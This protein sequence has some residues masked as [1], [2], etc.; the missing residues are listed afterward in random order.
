M[1]NHR[2]S[3]LSIISEI[4]SKILLSSII[5]NVTNLKSAGGN[6]VGLCPFHEEKSP[7]F[8]VR[9]KEAR[10]KC[11]GCGATGDHFDFLMKLRGL[12]FIEALEELKNLAGIT[13]YNQS[14]QKPLQ[15][16][17][18]ARYYYVLKLA[19]KFFSHCLQKHPKSLDYL[20]K[21]RGLSLTMIKEA[22]LGYCPKSSEL[23]LNYLQKNGVS[24]AEAFLC[25]L[26]KKDHM[27]P[28]FFDRITFPINDFNGHCIAFGARTLSLDSSVPKYINSPSNEFYEK[29]AAF[30][31][32]Y[33]S[34][35]AIDS[36]ASPYLVEGYFDAMAFWA[37]GFAAMALC[38]TSFSI[39]HALK[40]K[41]LTHHINICFDLDKAGINGLKSCLSILFSQ[42]LKADL[43]IIDQKDPGV[44]LEQKKIE[45][46]REK[47]I[48]K[49]DAFCFLLDLASIKASDNIDA[50]LKE[51]DELLPI[52]NS[53]K[54]DL[55]KRQYVSYF[56]NKI[57]EEPNIIWQ[58]LL[59]KQNKNKN[60][61]VTKN[62][63]FKNIP[64]P[65]TEKIILEILWIYPALI[66]HI[67][68]SLIDSL[69]DN[70]KSLFIEI[71]NSMNVETAVKNT[72]F[73]E[74]LLLLFKQKNQLNLSEPEALALIKSFNEQSIKQKTQESITKNLHNLK[75]A[76][77]NK[78]VEVMINSLKK[79]SELLALKRNKP[80]ADKEI[81]IEE[82]PKKAL[83]INTLAPKESIFSDEE[84]W[85]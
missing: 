63:G 41:K 8:N 72:G 83:K 32:A 17:K 60:V 33:E 69:S 78:D 77:E 38:G 15:E 74:F 1:K 34:K 67:D 36:G 14:S 66:N 81:K 39:E 3:S 75:K 37:A 12:D 80:L 21:E 52:F 55:L 30:Y 26:L 45:V 54:R 19:Q 51:I 35:K 20:T 9:D 50:R 18:K 2:D 46:L 71:K 70:F 7:S 6:L 49:K 56:A 27:T 24:S 29:K 5:K 22:N 82:V 53:I 13:T 57:N 85:F 16:Q 73:N 44:Y 62:L 76:Q 11:F 59:V 47:I 84:E 68:G 42:D 40:I 79:H 43:V 23:F 65:H 31:G 28:H 61:L 10:F 25:G 64:I 48:N 4:K 58:D